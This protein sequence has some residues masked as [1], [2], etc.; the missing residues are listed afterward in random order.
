MKVSV[1]VV[2][3]FAVVVAGAAASPAADQALTR[4]SFRK[5]AK[6]VCPGVVNVKIRS[7]IVFNGR[8]GMG[9]PSLPQ[10]FPLDEGTRELLEKLLESQS[11]NWSQTDREGYRYRGSGSGVVVRADGYV[12]TSNHVIEKAKAGDIEVSM[13][14]GRSFTKVTVVGQD[15]LTDL[16][17]LKV[18]G[19]TDLPTVAWGDSETL[20]VG[21]HVVAI[22]NPLEFNNSVSEGIVSAKHRSIKKTA[23][24][25]LIQTTAMINPGNSGGALVD[26]DGKLVGINMAIA[27]STGLW[28]GLGFAIPSKT[29][30]DVSDQI[31]ARGKVGRGYLG[32]EMAPLPA[33]FAQQVGYSQEF[34]IVVQGVRGGS[35]AEKGG[36]QRYDIIAKVNG[37]EIRET[38]DMH[39]SI[40]VR[41]AGEEV[42]LEVFRD[43]GDG[44]LEQKSVK[45]ALAERPSQGEMDRDLRRTPE[46]DRDGPG[47]KVV[48]PAAGM[49][50]MKVTPNPKGK[51]VMV[52]EVK[53]GSPVALAGI[54]PGDIVLD[55]NRKPVAS[56]PDIQKAVKSNQGDGQVLYVER[57]AGGNSLVTVPAKE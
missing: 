37:K 47:K 30:K 33:A 45:V 55:V 44:K 11:P 20:E 7:G 4:D 14:D 23:I 21:D 12:V 54:E 57:K 50:G 36:L 19:V 41:R 35:A 15:D 26:L 38:S 49:L 52:D 5:V 56:G 3:M 42:T 31:I 6:A 16:A 46:P 29:A 43:G 13:P 28:N 25:D 22:G 40:G 51:G 8:G 18:E 1:A 27:T 53:A 24:E 39:R 32:I 17:V 10:D 48:D 34:G 2:M 9:R